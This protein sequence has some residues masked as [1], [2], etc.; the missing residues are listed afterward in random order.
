M[1]LIMKS[2]LPLVSLA[3]TTLGSPFRLNDRAES[4]NSTCKKTKV[5]V[6]GAGAAGI[7]AAASPKIT[8]V[9]ESS[10]N[11]LQQA[12]HNA[13]VDDFMIIEYNGEIGGRV[14]H[15]TFGK[16]PNGEPYT[17]ELGANWYAFQSICSR[18]LICCAGSK[19]SRAEVAHQILS[20][21]W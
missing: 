15:T 16:D 20:G 3:V 11:P 13:S 21:H 4:N 2:T 19:V 8:N 14:K 7:F 17:V 5:A 6:L 12:L 9:L 1:R 10:A 18:L